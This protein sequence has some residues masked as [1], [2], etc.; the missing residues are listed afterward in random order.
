MELFGNE[1]EGSILS[2][3]KG[4]GLATG[5]ET[6]RKA[7]CSSLT[8]FDVN[9]ELT[10]KGVANHTKVVEAVFKFAQ[11]LNKK[12]PQEFVADDINS[13]GELK[14]NF[15][16]R[17][18]ALSL[19]KSYSRRLAHTDESEVDNLVKG[20]FMSTYNANALK[21][22]AE[23]L[24]DSN[25]VMIFLMSPDLEDECKKQEHYMMTKYIVKDISGDLL[26]AIEKPGKAS[27][28]LH[29]ANGL[30]AKDTSIAELDGN[31]CVAPQEI[32]SGVYFM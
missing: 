6:R 21:D 26:K 14:Y 8:K 2:Y 31:F 10:K 17:T 13:V 11:V 30:I 7:M 23:M 25:R 24:C 9:I 18:D 29:I 28:D 3:L 20:N 1:G 16:E 4:K 15:P 27:V 19:V 32:E 22:I 5:L 12:G